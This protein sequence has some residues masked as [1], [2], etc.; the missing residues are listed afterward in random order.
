MFWRLQTQFWE[1]G[2]WRRVMFCL[3]FGFSVCTIYH[4]LR[5]VRKFRAAL[6]LAESNLINSSSWWSCSIGQELLVSLMLRP[7]GPHWGSLSHAGSWRCFFGEPRMKSGAPPKHLSHLLPTDGCARGDIKPEVRW[8]EPDPLA[9]LGWSLEPL[10]VHS[11]LGLVR[12]TDAISKS[13][14]TQPSDNLSATD[15]GLCGFSWKIYCCWK[16]FQA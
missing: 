3:H 2:D 16:T 12:P 4:V 7:P 5:Q 6:G 1:K 11:S 10:K 9:Y 15:L 13:E 14:K 8:E